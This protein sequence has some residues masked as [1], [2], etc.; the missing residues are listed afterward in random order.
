MAGRIANPSQYLVQRFQQPKYVQALTP[1]QRR[2]YNDPARFKKAEAGRQSGKSHGLLAWLLGGGHNETSLVFARTFEQVKAI[3]LEPAYELNE[4][5]DLGLHISEAKGEITERSG[6]CIKMTGIRDVASAEKFRGRRYRRIVGDE[7]QSYIDDLIK[8]IV[9]K[10][11]QPTLLKHGGDMG[12]AGTPGTVPEGFWYDICQGPNAWPVSFEKPWTI[13]DNPHIPNAELVIEDVLRANG[14]TRDNPT[15]LREYM[16]RW[17]RD[18]GG[19]IYQWPGLFESA[20]TA[21]TTVLGIDVGYDD[22]MGYVVCRMTERPHVYVIRAFTTTQSLPHEIF[23]TIK[24]L[25]ERYNINHMIGDT[26]GGGKMTIEQLNQQFGL[27]IISAK[28]TG[29]QGKRANIDMA[30]GMLNAGNLH[31]CGPTREDD[32]ALELKQEWSVLPWNLERTDHLTGYQ[33]E[34]SDALLY[35]L[36][37]FLQRPGEESKRGPDPIQ[38]ELEKRRRAA[39]RHGQRNARQKWRMQGDLLVPDSDGLWLPLAA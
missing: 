8:H 36:K 15:F 21:G 13:Y 39:Q 34:L 10:A 7:T 25:Q 29:E 26:G 3:Y 37:L 17:V 4:R 20:P 18:T 5:F 30:R 31:L 12:L 1:H 6:H 27:N 11:L 33:D 16:C 24:G 22:G 38:L 28:T 23:H 32:G 35:A 19:L 14:W 2:I 9:Q